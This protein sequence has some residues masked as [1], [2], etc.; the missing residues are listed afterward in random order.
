MIV[1]FV[2]K[3]YMKITTDAELLSLFAQLPRRDTQPT[4]MEI[5][6]YPYNRFEEV[7]SRI[8][9]FYIDPLA[10]HG[11]NNLWL[12]ALWKATKQCGEVP[13]YDNVECVIEEF[14]E[15]KKIDIII[16]LNAF[17]IAIENKITADLYNPLDIY[18]KYI[19]YR[20]SDKK[21]I[22]L[23]LSVFPILDC[24]KKARIKDNGFLAILYKDLF[25]QV[26]KELRNY[27]MGC[28]QKYLTYMFDFMKTIENM[29]NDSF[30]REN[31][32]FTQNKEMI[33][34]LI[35]RYNNYKNDILS[36]QKDNIAELRS[37]ISEKT[38]DSWWAWQDW[39]LCIA[40]NEKSYKIGIESSYESTSGGA[41]EKFHIYITTW[42]KNDWSVYKHQVIEAFADYIKLDENCNN[43][44]YLHL[45]II[46]GNN[47]DKIIDVLAETYQKLKKIAESLDNQ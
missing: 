8:L 7:C 4:F 37:L 28:D 44:V 12:S 36:K 40:F 46:E 21:Q 1:V 11:L 29:N 26:Y 35:D 33:E 23:V 43:R 13:F 16:K 45:P 47:K 38:K 27:V 18:A 17:V 30:K 24:K 6:K 15:N 34:K 31:D 2:K 14:A 42:R 32:F 3:K 22:L 25:A 39:D 5:C 9:R 10:E 19:K 41:C 20:Y